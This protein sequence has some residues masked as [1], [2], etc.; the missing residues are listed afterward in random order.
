MIRAA[1]AGVVGFVL[2]FIESMIVMKLK[3]LETIEFGGLAPFINVWAMNFFFMFAIL[4]QLTNW[5][6]NKES[7]KEDKSF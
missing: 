7:L 2:I 5:Y 3:G 6:M 1:I 4:T